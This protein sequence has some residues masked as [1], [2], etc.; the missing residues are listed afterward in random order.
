MAVLTSCDTECQNNFL[1]DYNKRSVSYSA[2]SGSYSVFYPEY[3]GQK[4]Y[5]TVT[6]DDLKSQNVY[7]IFSNVSMSLSDDNPTVSGYSAAEIRDQISR[8][9]VANTTYDKPL[10]RGSTVTPLRDT[11][12]DTKNFWIQQNNTGSVIQK[13]CVCLKTVVDGDKQLSVWKQNSLSSITDEMAQTIADTFMK[14]GDNNDIYDW[15]THIYGEEWGEHS[16]SDLIEPNDNI[17]ILLVDDDANAKTITLGYF[18]KKD[19]YKTSNDS[20]SN[21]RIMF[22]VNGNYY[23]KKADGEL[24]WKPTNKYPS[25][26]HS[27]LAHEFQ[28]MIHFYQKSVKHN[29]TELS[30]TFL[31]EMCSLVTEDL[32]ADK[33]GI[34]GP[35]GRKTAECSDYRDIGLKT[36][37]EDYNIGRLPYFNDYNDK[38]SLFAWGG[39]DTA[40]RYSTAFAFGAFLARNYGGP[41]LFRDIV[42]DESISDNLIT[43]KT[44]ASLETLLRKWGATCILSNLEGVEDGLKYNNGSSWMSFDIDGIEYNLGSINLFNYG[45]T[46]HIYTSVGSNE[47]AIGNISEIYAATNRYALV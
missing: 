13:P 14:V 29:K 2:A 12:G 26:I 47:R 35:R 18:W 40:Y 1:N 27:T 20:T 46:P 41:Q 31:N 25:T 33:L 21:Q 9:L 7:F 6:V 10:S 22:Y 30:S 16:S 43:N 38:Y 15:V 34:Y 11:V 45:S 42:Q 37:N 4:T 5:L 44:G 36:T 17:T 28:H 19:N 39:S 3:D 24:I 8:Q 32:V 23:A